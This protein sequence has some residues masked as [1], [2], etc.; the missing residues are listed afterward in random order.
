[1]IGI[2]IIAG[3][4]RT[5][6]TLIKTNGE[7]AG[8]IKE[9]QKEKES[10]SEAAAGESVAISLPGVTIGRNL[11]G[12]ETLYSEIS[13]DEFHKIK[14]GLKKYMSSREIDVLKEILEIK[15]KEDPL[16]GI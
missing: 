1:V 14:A 10:V 2:E 7:K 8:I 6:E 16:W 3:K 11:K 15:R 9:I 4:I 5:G 13:V 12:N